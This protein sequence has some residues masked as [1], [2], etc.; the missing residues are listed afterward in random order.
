M[1]FHPLID[2]AVGDN[3]DQEYKAAHGIG[4]VHLGE[5]DL[6]FK[7][8]LRTYFI[9]YEDVGRVFRRVVSVPARLCCGK[10][11]LNLEH[12]VVCGRDGQELAQIQ[13]PDTKAARLLMEELRTA[14]PHAAIG[15]PVQK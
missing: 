8:G 2:S 11:E 10:G 7:S 14:A 12:L 4:L 6:F 15:R 13:L 1:K 5:K 3:L 9:P